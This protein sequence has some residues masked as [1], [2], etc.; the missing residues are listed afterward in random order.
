MISLSLLF[1]VFVLFCFF[2]SN[3]QSVD[4]FE[5]SN[6]LALLKIT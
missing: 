6:L 5:N 4:G 3:T 2:T 1:I